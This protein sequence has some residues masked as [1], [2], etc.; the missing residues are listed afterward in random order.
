[1]RKH[2]LPGLIPALAFNLLIAAAAFAEVP[3]PT[4]A[5]VPIRALPAPETVSPELARLIEAPP[6]P[7]WNAHP[8]TPTNGGP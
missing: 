8:K 6:L 2:V 5:E 1:M 7:Y 3:L 4:R